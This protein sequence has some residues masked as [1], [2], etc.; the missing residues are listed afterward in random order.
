MGWSMSVG[1]Y[2]TPPGGL[3]PIQ[4]YCCYHPK[5]R[6][7]RDELEVHFAA[8][9]K[10]GELEIW[11]DQKVTAGG[12]LEDEKNSYFSSAHIHLLFLSHYFFDNE[13]CWNDMLQ[14]LTWNRAGHSCALPILVS[15]V[16]YEGS[17]VRRL[18]VLPRNKALSQFTDR[19]LGYVEIVKG[20]R[21]VM[22]VIRMR[23]QM[24]G[25]AASF[26]GR[27]LEKASLIDQV[28]T[29]SLPARIVAIG[30]ILFEQ[31]HYDEALDAYNEAIRLDPTCIA[32]Y[33]GKARVL[34]TLAMITHEKLNQLR[35]FDDNG[36]SSD[37]QEGPEWQ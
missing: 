2:V 21:E 11:H 30:D 1:R 27:Q 17:P 19:N 9:K 23:E 33:I 20:V 3:P 8:L 7:E 22:Q 28:S 31:Q 5:N 4:A 36:P 14:I 12:D 16:D 32:A 34:D 26:T 35:P 29:A 18:Q 13:T 37:T 25:E 15:P 10:Q 6:K 24:K